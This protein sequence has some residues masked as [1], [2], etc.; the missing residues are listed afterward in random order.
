[1]MK[2]KKLY[3]APLTERNVVELEGEFCGS[4]TTDAGKGQT[5]ESTPQ[6]YQEFDGAASGDSNP[7]T[8]TNGS[9]TWD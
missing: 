8:N 4:I 6:E 5:I 3:Q 2:T 1:M 7:F 9:I